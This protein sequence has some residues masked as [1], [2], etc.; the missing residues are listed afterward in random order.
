MEKCP[1]IC[2]GMA[3]L[4]RIRTSRVPGGE[5]ALLVIDQKKQKDPSNLTI[6]GFIKAVTWIAV[7][8]EDGDMVPSA[9]E[10]DCCVD[11]QSLGAADAEIRMDEDD[12]FLL[13]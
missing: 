9:L 12:V 4:P 5:I 10:T 8:S 1:R 6:A 13:A 11:H 7:T 2:G 3:V